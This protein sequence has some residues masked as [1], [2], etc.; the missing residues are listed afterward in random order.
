M[1][2]ADPT[3]EGDQIMR[4][5]GPVLSAL[6]DLDHGQAPPLFKPTPTRR[7]TSRPADA[8]RLQLSALRHEAALR[9]R[10]MS[11]EQA[12]GEVADAYEVS[13]ETIRSWKKKLGLESKGE[14][15]RSIRMDDLLERSRQKLGWP[16]PSV[17]QII[18]AAARYGN[19]LRK[20][21]PKKAKV[22]GKKSLP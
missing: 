9:R 15:A 8:R 17:P 19:E 14:I 22:K 18:K 1:E 3:E 13:V 11:Q 7:R 21:E 20:I 16:V 10:G 6:D 2:A 5:L 12:R 4:L